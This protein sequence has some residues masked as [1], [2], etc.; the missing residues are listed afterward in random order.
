[1]LWRAGLRISEAL[2]LHEGDLEPARGA[3]LVVLRSAL[4][5]AFLRPAASF[6]ETG[7]SNPP[8]VP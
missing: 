7:T 5:Q 2:T 1:M 6:T 4:G 3:M 8:S